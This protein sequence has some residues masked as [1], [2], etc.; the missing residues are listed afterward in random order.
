MGNVECGVKVCLH[1]QELDRN[2]V[3]FSSFL[4][5]K[6]HTDGNKSMWWWSRGR[7]QARRP[8]LITF[9]RDKTLQASSSS[10]SSRVNGIVI[11]ARKEPCYLATRNFPP[12]RDN[13]R[14]YDRIFLSSSFGLAAVLDIFS[15]FYLWETSRNLV[16]VSRENKSEIYGVHAKFYFIAS[17]RN[18]LFLVSI[19]E[20]HFF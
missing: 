10:S 3:D 17:Q 19:R 12:L 6:G 9:L 13:G 1:W 5:A 20:R 11:V 4:R 18:K 14:V 16:T 8:L 7:G 15:I 2:R